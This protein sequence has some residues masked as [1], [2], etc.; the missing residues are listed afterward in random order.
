MEGDDAGDVATVLRR[1]A[2]QAA[3][4]SG[5]DVERLVR[6][7]R[8]EARR[9]HRA[10]TYED[11]ERLLLA[12]KPSGCPETLKRIA[13]HEAGHAVTRLVLQQGT[14]DVISINTHDG[15]AFNTGK[16]KP[17]ADTMETDLEA[18]LACILAGR[19]AEDV[20][21]GSISAGSG[22]SADS[23]LAKATKLAFTLECSFGFGKHQPLLFFDKDVE[24]S[25]LG[26]R[27]MLTAAV[28][29]RLADSYACAKEI[30]TTARGDVERLATILLE[31]ITLEG[32]SLQQA[33]DHLDLSKAMRA[34]LGRSMSD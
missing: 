32:S 9:D 10:I 6:I 26:L 15:R 34:D 23:D 33:I 30:I 2:A 17:L 22:G 24:A 12:D 18:E 14:I 7:A 13:I 8:L 3:G 16:S 1:L 27:Q 19:A 5:A 20:I 21:I 28:H 29:E 25:I 31:E 4:M 11:L